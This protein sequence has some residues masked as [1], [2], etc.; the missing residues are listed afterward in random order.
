VYLNPADGIQGAGI[1]TRMTGRN[2]GVLEG[3]GH[4][5]LTMPHLPLLA[6]CYLVSVGILRGTVMTPYDLH[7]RAYPFSVASDSRQQGVI[8]VEHAW[9][10]RA[11]VRG[12]G[13]HDRP[14]EA[15]RARAGR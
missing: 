10:H 8:H 6:G 1:N 2:L 12:E 4:V 9:E 5:D 7:V 13:D 11:A 3:P 15:V 14:L